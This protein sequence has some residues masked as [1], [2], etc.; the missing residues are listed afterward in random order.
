MLLY[1]EH[2]RLLGRIGLFL[3]GRHADIAQLDSFA[4]A[5]RLAGRQLPNPFSDVLKTLDRSA[6]AVYWPMADIRSDIWS[7]QRTV[8]L[9]DAVAAFL[10]TAGVGA[11]AAM[12]SAAALA[13]ELSRAGR[14]HMGYAL[15]LYE[16]RQRH[17]VEMAQTNSRKLAKYMFVNSVYG[18]F[19][20]DQFM[21]FYT[22]KQ[23]IGDIS[24]VMEGA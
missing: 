15:S 8:L 23:L 9:G 1:A 2:H 17:R 13:D 18:A 3:A 16:K 20:R 7:R 6:P 5:D 14:T 24:K 11:S 19:L 22:L 12:D 10:P 4:Y 21:R